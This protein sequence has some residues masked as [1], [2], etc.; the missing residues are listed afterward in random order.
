MLD[1]VAWPAFLMG[2]IS[3]C[4]LP[5]GALTIRFWSPDDRTTAGL[6]AFGGGA[7][8]AAQPLRLTGGRR[9]FRGRLPITGQPIS[10]PVI[11]WRLGL[12]GR[13]REASGRQAAVPNQKPAFLPRNSS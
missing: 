7:L 12:T 3:A 6:M 2:I 4:Y 10:R 1:S 11:D 5:M 9:E 8:L 13:W